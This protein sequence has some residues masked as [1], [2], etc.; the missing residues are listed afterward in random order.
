LLLV[1]GVAVRY[2]WLIVDIRGQSLG[3]NE[4][5]LLALAG[6]AQHNL[7]ELFRRKRQ[8]HIYVWDY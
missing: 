3:M 2:S 5:V 8:K 6:K 7:S 4:S 1:L